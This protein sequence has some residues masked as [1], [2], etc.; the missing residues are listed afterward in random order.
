MNVDLVGIV[1]SLTPHVLSLGL[2]G[3]FDPLGIDGLVLLATILIPILVVRSRKSE[4]RYGTTIGGEAQPV[5]QAVS[6]DHAP[7][8]ISRST[9]RITLT[10]SVPLQSVPIDSPAPLPGTSSGSTTQPDS[11]VPSQAVPTRS[12]LLA[13]P[14]L[15]AT[16]LRLRSAPVAALALVVGLGFV[17]I[18]QRALLGV[19]PGPGAFAVWFAGLLVLVLVCVQA[20]RGIPAGYAIPADRV[21]ISRLQVALLCGIGVVSLYIWQ[22][23]PGRSV[24]DSSL[25]LVLL[26]LL[27]IAALVVAAAGPP[28]R[29]HIDRLRAWLG[30]HREDMLITAG[31]ALIAFVPRIY[32]LSSYPWALSGDEGT[33]AVT[34]Q[35]VLRGEFTNPFTS[36]PWGYPSL[37]FIF[38]G[39]LMD[40]AGETV[41][42]SRMLSAVLGTASVVA[43]YWLTRHHF[44]RWTGLVAA[45]I[46]ASFNFHLFWSRNAQNAIAPMFFIPL[47][48]L[49][50]D[51]GLV[52]RSRL[53]S[54]AAGLVIGLAQFFHPANRILFPIAAAYAVYAL[55]YLRPNTRAELARALRML[56]PNVLWLAAGAIVGHLPLLAYFN[57]N[58]VAFSDRS[59]QVSVFASGWLEQ[60]QVITGK[61]AVEILWLQFQH[62]AMLPF[63]TVA[64]GHFH[65]EV[66]FASWPLVVPLALG[67]AIVTLTFWRRSSFGLAMAFWATV[68]GLALTDGSPQTNRYT[69]SG[70]FLAIFAAIGIMAVASVLIRLVR[71]PRIP[72]AVLVATATLLIAGWHLNWYF[73]DPNPAAVSSDPNSQIANRLAHEA[74]LH[75]AGTTVYFSGLPRLSYGGFA[76]IPYIAPDANGIDVTEPWTASDPKPELT[77]PTLFA[78]VPDRLAELDVVRAWF[79]DGAITVSTL[80]NGEEILTTYFVDAP[81]IDVARGPITVLGA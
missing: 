66:P 19:D 38:Q 18:G 34:A 70:P 60:E 15:V 1:A 68:V 2:V 21:R 13:F 37:L 32:D 11:N 14:D 74:A 53:D 39:G 58:R 61:S 12:R 25:D 49:F 29:E 72:V 47:A 17:W 56:V 7:M 8:A 31:V 69:S 28:R 33:F 65:P 44:G 73:E 79:P 59:N 9:A 26:W 52:G 51:R 78:F 4:P 46:A 45:V 27:S 62:A 35:S 67:M 30:R 42:G 64:G 10:R 50:L 40:L 71:L 16:R 23:A 81:A 75:G 77:G 24:T 5:D 36:G 76:N 54:L 55:L 3:E 22:A 80:P 6:G 63:N 57:T 48:L 43:I 41:G 20:G